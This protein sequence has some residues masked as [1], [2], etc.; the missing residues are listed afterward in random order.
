ML[1]TGNRTTQLAAHQPQHHAEPGRP[2]LAHG[3][4]RHSAAALR[5][6]RLRAGGHRRSRIPKARPTANTS[7]TTWRRRG[8]IRWRSASARSWGGSAAARP[9]STRPAGAG[10]LLAARL[11]RHFA[12][13][14]LWG[15]THT[16]SLRTRVSTLDQRGL[17]NYSWP[18]FRN[19]RQ[20]HRFS[21]PGF[22]KRRA[23]CGPSTYERA[24]RLRPVDAAAQ[25]GHH[26]LLSLHVPPRRA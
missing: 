15:L 8:A 23:T 11:L 19:Q 3:D 9:A 10:R 6:R 14:N 12:R 20:S 1:I 7:S 5:A 13:N 22:T 26:P 24:G 4:D 18:H 2:A 17:L 16:L 25:Q 21:S